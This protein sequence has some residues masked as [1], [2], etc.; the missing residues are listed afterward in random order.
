MQEEIFDFWKFLAGIGIFLWGMHQLEGAIKELG[1]KSFRNLL[2]R[3]TDSALKG[4]LIG[5]LITAILQSSSLVTLMVLAFLGAGVL[6]LKNA[7]GVILG[8]NQIGRAH[9]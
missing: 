6:N 7:I 2:Q 1:G 8:A 5:T 4:I 9:V 3:F